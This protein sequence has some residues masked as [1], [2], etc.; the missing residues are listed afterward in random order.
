MKC[1]I[2]ITLLPSNEI[3]LYFLWEKTYQQL[4]LALVETQDANKQVKVGVSFPEYNEQRFHLGSKIRLLAPSASD[5][6]AVN[7]N[8]WLSRLS[9]YIHITSIRDVPDKIEGYAHY[10][11]VN[12]RKS[13]VEKAKSNAERLGIPYKQALEKLEGRN[14]ELSKAP[15]IHMKSLSTG[16]RFRLLIAL[17][18]TSDNQS[19]QRFSTYGLSSTSSVPL[20]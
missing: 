6:E 4:H 14:E 12:K 2:E 10:S 20:F 13:N 17:E 1:F 19:E 11:R 7:I 18:R 16:Q 5:L 15:F 3:P 9:D 8:K